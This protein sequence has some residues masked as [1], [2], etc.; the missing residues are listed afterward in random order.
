MKNISPYDRF[1]YLIRNL[2]N[3]QAMCT[4]DFPLPYMDDEKQDLF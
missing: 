1:N 2:K 4:K 3:D